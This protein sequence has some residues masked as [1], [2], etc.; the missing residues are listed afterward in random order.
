[1]AITKPMN[2]KDDTKKK[3]RD[4]PFIKSRKT[5]ITKIT[6][7]RFITLDNS[8]IDSRG[9]SSTSGPWNFRNSIKHK[10]H[11]GTLKIHYHSLFETY[12]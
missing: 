2:I 5:S 10:T 4:I 11:T 6:P 9:S 12:G 1:M 8:F 7:T 3:V